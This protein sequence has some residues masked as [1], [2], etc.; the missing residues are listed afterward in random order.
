MWLPGL[1]VKEL[2]AQRWVSVFGMGFQPS[3][4]AKISFILYLGAYLHKWDEAS[5]GLEKLA[6][7]II[8]LG[9]VA[10]LILLEPDLG[11]AVLLCGV[12]LVMAV[13][14]GARLTRLIFIG[15]AL[16]VP[17]VIYAATELEYVSGRF[18]SVWSPDRNTQVWHSVHSI[19]S[20]GLFG[21]GLGAGVHK[22]QYYTQIQSDFIAAVLGEELGFMGLTVV[23]A[24]YASLI[25]CGL[26]IL[27]ALRCRFAQ[28]V[29]TG[30]LLMLGLAAVVNLAVAT[31]IAPAKGIPLP[32]VSAGGSA[33][34]GGGIAVGLLLSFARQE[35]LQR[36]QGLSPEEALEARMTRSS[37][38]R[39]MVVPDA[40]S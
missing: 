37:S 17:V 20:G 30:L 16:A 14:A 32:F 25:L 36:L 7:P 5:M 19:G 28:L 1:G 11:T 24:L 8:S 15:I 26:K 31:A 35:I 4:F 10:A 6:A 29:G 38:T 2:G 23:I 9:F 13:V 22:L 39:Q 12:S 40:T 18:D 34:L 21:K 3:E 27:M 33:L